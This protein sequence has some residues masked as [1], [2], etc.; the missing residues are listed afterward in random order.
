MKKTARL[1]SLFLLT[2]WMVIALG[3]PVFA[4]SYDLWVGS[5]QVT[6]ANKTNIPGVKGG[7]ASFDPETNTLKFEGEVTG[8]TG[9]H[10]NAQIC[11]NINLN[12]EGNIK[13]DDSIANFGIRML[14]AKNIRFQ[15]EDSFFE[16]YGKIAAVYVKDGLW[17]G[18][19]IN[20]AEG[21]FIA[22]PDN[23]GN[24][25]GFHEWMSNPSRRSH[26][27]TN[28]ECVLIAGSDGKA[29]KTVVI[30]PGKASPYYLGGSRISSGNMN[31]IPV[32]E[33]KAS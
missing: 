10:E 33:G 32:E 28:E 21:L 24:L 16:L 3:V 31:D 9:L 5:T 7:T 6:D 8:V 2:L 4:A 27:E 17:D 13:L 14:N 11:A 29:A 25:L 19:D 20:V 23:C 15:G 12:I 22:A 26:P 30:K 18:S 1:F